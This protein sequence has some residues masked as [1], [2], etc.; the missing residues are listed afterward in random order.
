MNEARPT[1]DI[2]NHILIFIVGNPFDHCRIA[3]QRSAL[4]GVRGK[5]VLH[6]AVAR[7]AYVVK[8]L[9]SVAASVAYKDSGWKLVKAFS[10]G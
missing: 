2:I 5:Q 9:Y 6:D 3:K 1:N 10:V 7:L 8:L 4:N